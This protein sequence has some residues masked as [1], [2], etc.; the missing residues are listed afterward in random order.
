[1]NLLLC[2]T[3]IARRVLL[4]IF[5]IDIHS[6]GVPNHDCIDTH[7]NCSG[8]RR[9]HGTCFLRQYHT[10][11]GQR[12]CKRGPRDG[13]RWSY[14]QEG[15]SIVNLGCRCA[16]GNPLVIAGHQ[17]LAIR[18]RQPGCCACAS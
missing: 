14:R 4:R 10:R 13:G 16:G 18:R 17:F 8:L 1:M 11:R 15:G 7:E 5:L 3:F 9:S 6:E 12:Y 2:Y